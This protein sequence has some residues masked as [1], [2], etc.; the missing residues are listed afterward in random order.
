MLGYKKRIICSLNN[1]L[2]WLV[3]VISV[4]SI[5]CG[6]M[7]LCHSSRGIY[8]YFPIV[9]I[10]FGLMTLVFFYVY[11]NVTWVTMLVI[12]FMF[13][14]YTLALFVL[15]QE[16]YPKGVYNIS[17]NNTMS[18][19]TAVLM[20]YE[21]LMI[22]CALYVGQKKYHSVVTVDEYK[23]KLF[24]NRNFSHMNVLLVA[25]VLVT[26]I[27]FVMYPS[28]FTNY[29]F[30][31]NKN[32]EYL[33]DTIISS[34]AGLP[35]GIRWIGYTFGEA[36]RYILIE[37]FILKIYRK[38]TKKGSMHSRF[39]WISV[40]L[41]TLNALI[42][43][44]RLMLG[45]FMSLTFFYQI[46]QLYPAKRK[47][48]IFFGGI[49]GILGIGVITITYWSYALTYQSFSQMIQGY[50]NGFYNVYQAMSAYNNASMSLLGKIGMFFWGDGLGNVNVLSLFIDGINSSDIYNYY[51]YGTSFNG[52]AVLPLLSQMCFYFSP[53]LGP[54]F[55]FFVIL[56]AKKFENASLNSS[57]NIVIG[58]FC[59]F[60]FAATPFMYNYSTVI[61]I[62]TVVALPL[63]ICSYINSKN[64][65][66]GNFHGL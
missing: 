54:L 9:T 25:F 11:K 45:I 30:I 47:L 40:L 1:K 34:Q 4:L 10:T 65:V 2:Y 56:L 51:I 49:I 20:M 38:Y 48:F 29:S 17:I 60:V 21:I 39:W 35:S 33:T 3:I 62:L 55:S 8:T 15:H 5:S 22:Y 41:A 19:Q 14:R 44:Q 31:I 46:Y 32:L 53:V 12:I 64:I 66:A 63:C 42:T 6:I 57:G 52:G 37:Y 18:L 16:G 50:T 27:L 43:N 58:Q 36:T 61:H 13:L 24:S 28:L 23:K 59:A 7:S 26:C